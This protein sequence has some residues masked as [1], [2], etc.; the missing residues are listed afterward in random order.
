L[1]GEIIMK[2][3]KELSEVQQNK[4]TEYFLRRILR[5][6]IEDGW[7]P[8]IEGI[9]DFEER[10]VEAF[11]EAN[12]LH[13]PWFAGQCVMEHCGEELAAM[14][15]CDAE[16]ALYNEDNGPRVIAMFMINDIELAA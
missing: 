6:I 3:F 14:A 13:T 12:R 7:I 2:T 1:K 9:D 10:L 4:A 15:L 5:E 11:A 16:E 8:K